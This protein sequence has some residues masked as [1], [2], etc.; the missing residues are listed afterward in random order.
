MAEDHDFESGL[1]S[2]IDLR[3]L[4]KFPGDRAETQDIVNQRDNSRS[5][6]GRGAMADG[7]TVIRRSNSS[8]FVIL[9]GSNRPSKNSKPHDGEDAHNV[10][11]V[12]VD[13]AHSEEEEKGSRGYGN[14]K[15]PYSNGKYLTAVPNRS[16]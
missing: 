6:D 2:R 3:I 5:R 8:R 16:G 14:G 9:C 10:F 4:C 7:K 13:C 11:V 12:Q 1:K 15:E